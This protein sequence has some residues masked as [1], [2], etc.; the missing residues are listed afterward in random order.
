MV[1]T[2]NLSHGWHRLYAAG[3]PWLIPFL[4]LS[5]IGGWP[6]MFPH[7]RLALALDAK[8]PDAVARGAVEEAA[9]LWAPYG[10]AIAQ[11]D[12]TSARSGFPARP[13]DAALTVR[14]AEPGVDAARAG[15]ARSRQFASWLKG[16]RSRRFSCTTTP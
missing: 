6:T 5:S 13:I 4:V 16:S 11:L 1:T 3:M 10:V 14:V 9:A 2:K 15:R 7:V 8:L 12:P